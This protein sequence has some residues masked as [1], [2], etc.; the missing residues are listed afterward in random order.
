MCPVQMVRSVYSE[1]CMFSVDEQT[2]RGQTGAQFG[3]LAAGCREE[4]VVL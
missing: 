4:G 2:E 3:G 1:I